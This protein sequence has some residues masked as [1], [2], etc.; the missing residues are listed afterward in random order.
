MKTRLA[1]LAAVAALGLA[2]AAQATT[3]QGTETIDGAT[4][5]ISLT[6]NGTIGV[7]TSSDITAFDISM[8]DGAYSA[9]IN[10]STG[11]FS[12][13]TNDLTATPT[14]LSFNFQVDHTQI[15]FYDSTETDTYFGLN[16]YA[17]SQDFGFTFF[18]FPGAPGYPGT[19][20]TVPESGELVLATAPSPAPEPSTWALMLVGVG[21]MGLMLRRARRT[22]GFVSAP[23]V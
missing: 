4:I 5:D 17:S 8:V 19:S 10:N 15:F 6:T 1:C 20:G 9:D 7:I 23:A 2:A 12:S 18:P 3:Y 22:R 16:D 21:G 14:E 11:Y 13:W